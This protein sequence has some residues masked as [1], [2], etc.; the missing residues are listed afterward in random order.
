MQYSAGLNIDSLSVSTRPITCNIAS[1]QVF[2]G[3]NFVTR[4]DGEIKCKA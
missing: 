3:K 1:A 4:T 2:E